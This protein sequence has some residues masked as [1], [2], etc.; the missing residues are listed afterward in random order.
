MATNPGGKNGAGVYQ[1]IISRMPPHLVYVEPFLGSGAIMRLKRPA[2]VNIGLDLDAGAVRQ[3]RRW[4]QLHVRNGEGRS[5]RPTSPGSAMASPLAGSG[6][7]SWDH[8]GP[9]SLVPA[10]V[11]PHAGSG[12]EV[13]RW[14]IERGD[15]VEFLRTYP[16]AGGEL[17]YCDPP[18]MHETRGRCDLYRYEMTDQD[19]VRLLGTLRALRCFVMISGYWTQLYA[20]MLKDWHASTFQTTNRAGQRTTEWLW[21]NFPEPVALHDY[22][23]LGRNFRERERI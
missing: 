19:H 13:S 7:A 11:D 16:F 14:R 2:R 15:A 4:E 12:D 10:M 22:R 18:Y 6:D 8:P 20:D 23:Y 5:T 3:F 21:C 1:T 9:V 17:V